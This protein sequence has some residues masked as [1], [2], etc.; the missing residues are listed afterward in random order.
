MSKINQVKEFMTESGQKV[1]D[2]PAIGRNGNVRFKLMQE[3]NREYL[4]AIE[5]GDIVEVLDALV[6][7]QYVL[8][9]TILS[10]G[11]QDVFDEAY[12]RVHENNMTKRPFKKNALGKVIKPKGFKPVDLSDFI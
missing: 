5:A 12:N 3:E 6:D 9:G 7:M 8:N 2:K 1:L 11:L 10:H 4:E